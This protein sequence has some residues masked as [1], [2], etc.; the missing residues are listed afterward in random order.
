MILESLLSSI[1]YF[2]FIILLYLFIYNPP[3]KVVSSSVVEIMVVPA[4]LYIILSWRWYS[5]IKIFKV[6]F[7]L[8]GLII[9]FSF[10]RELGLSESVFFRANVL[11]LLEAIIIPC[12]L[13]NFYSTIKLG[14]N[15]FKEIILVGVIAAFITLAMIFSPELNASIKA[16]FKSTDFD[17]SVAFRSFGLSEGLTFS[18]GVVQGLVFALVFYYSRVN[19]KYLLLLPLLLISIFFNA[20]SGLI[21]VVFILAYFSIVEFNFKF[22]GLSFLVGLILYFFLFVTDIFADYRETIEWAFDFFVQISDF[23][24]G[25]ANQSDTNTFATLFGD[26]AVFPQ[27]ASEWIFGS[28]ENIFSSKSGNSDIGYIIQLNYGGVIYIFLFILLVS[29]LLWRIS[30]I[31][32]KNKWFILLISFTIII[33]NVKGLFISVTPNFRLVMLMYLYLIYEDRKNINSINTFFPSRK[34]NALI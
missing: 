5:L 9:F 17:D 16:N 13:I 10:V 6:E 18:Y 24:S 32:K 26:M 12:A 30:F 22:I 1:K 7:F 2:F 33:G 34:K 31:C 27:N 23:L 25:D 8:F 4:M 11:L 15:L 20:R 14:N 19:S 21:P 29:F 28:G 3:F